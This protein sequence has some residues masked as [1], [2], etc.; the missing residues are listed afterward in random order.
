MLIRSP[1]TIYSV[2]Q[3]LENTP[4]VTAYCAFVEN[5]EPGTL[6]LLHEWKSQRL[7]KEM[8]LYTTQLDCPDFVSCFIMN[9]KVW[10]IFRYYKGTPLDKAVSL[11]PSMEEKIQ[12][13]GAILELVFFRKLPPYLQYELC[14]PANLVIDDSMCARANYMLYEPDKMLH[15]CF[16][17][18]SDA[19]SQENALFDALQK[20]LSTSFAM[21]FAKE[22]QNKGIALHTYAEQ[23]ERSEFRDGLQIYHLFHEQK[24]EWLQDNAKKEPVKI[25]WQIRCWKKM[26]AHIDIPIKCLYWLAVLGLWVLFGIL[27]AR[28]P[29]A[30]EDRTRI[31]TIG[32]QTVDES[33][34]NCH[35]ITFQICFG[36]CHILKHFPKQECKVISKQFLYNPEEETNNTTWQEKTTE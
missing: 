25:K 2:I 31:V 13:W 4:K 5:K 24:S 9:R 17:N 8:L 11:L 34:R 20:R 7:A 23:L 18:K 26:F 1:D 36:K 21:L 29:Q 35:E 16:P 28:K 33:V 14:A 22:L 19:T 27:C 12:L 30:P 3:I 10:T 6:Y 32:T 15:T